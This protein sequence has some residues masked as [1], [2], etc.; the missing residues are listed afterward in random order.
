MEHSCGECEDGIYDGLCSVCNG[1]GE[2][3]YDGSTC[4]SC[5]GKGTQKE[6]CDCGRGQE[7]L[8]KEVF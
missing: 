1:S 4:H 7:R 6:Y 8:E 5:H 2:G 3:Q